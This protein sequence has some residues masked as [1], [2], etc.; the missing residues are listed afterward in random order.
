VVR[1]LCDRVAVMYLGRIMEEG[2]VADVFA[3]PAH[4]YTRALLSATPMLN[5]AKR[6]MR[7]ILPGEPPS[8]SNP[9]SGCVFRTRCPHA[10]AACAEAVPPLRDFGPQRIACI[11]AEELN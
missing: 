4:P 1:H 10:V 8:P 7:I 9:P 6:A 2:R 3:R 11:R 5:A